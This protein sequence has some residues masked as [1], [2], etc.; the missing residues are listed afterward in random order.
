MTGNAG[1]ISPT[2]GSDTIMFS[3]SHL[4]ASIKSPWTRTPSSTVGNCREDAIQQV[5]S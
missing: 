4:E 1:F 5:N 3:S 2:F